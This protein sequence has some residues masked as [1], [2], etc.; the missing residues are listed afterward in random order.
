MLKPAGAGGSTIKVRKPSIPQVAPPPPPPPAP[1]VNQPV[2]K[3]PLFDQSRN[4]GKKCLKN[5]LEKI[6]FFRP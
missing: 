3:T 1:P 4:G 6:F 5:K 2:V